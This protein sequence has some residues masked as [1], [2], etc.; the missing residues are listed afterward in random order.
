MLDLKPTDTVVLEISSFQLESTIHFKPHVAVWTNFSQNH[1][2]RHKDLEEYF[3][4]KC[5]IFA[6]QDA[7]DFAVLNFLD[8]QH[9]E[10]GRTIESQGAFF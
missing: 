9:Q 1:L 7:Q 8:P 10:I 6:N 4:A 2:D 5:K 3:Q